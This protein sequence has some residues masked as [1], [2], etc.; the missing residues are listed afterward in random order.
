MAKQKQETAVEKNIAEHVLVPKH[1]VLSQAEAEELL[2]RLGVTPDKLPY[3]LPSDPMVKK[4]KA[5]VGD[6]IK[7]TRVSETAGEAVYYR[8]VWGEG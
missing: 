5:R 4:L 8:V 7:I 6:I 1:E 2:K 3:I